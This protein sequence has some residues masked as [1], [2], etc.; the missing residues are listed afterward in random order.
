[1]AS[2]AT[3]PNTS[4]QADGSRTARAPAT[5]RAHS[6][7]LSVPSSSADSSCAAQAATSPASGPPPAMTSFSFPA[8]A[9]LAT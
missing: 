7:L 8:L 1:M 6:S 2:T 3:R 9:G 4:S 5:T